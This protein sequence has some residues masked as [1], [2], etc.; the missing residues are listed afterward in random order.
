MKKESKI[1]LSLLSA[2]SLP[3]IMVLGLGAYTAMY[4]PMDEIPTTK[5]VRVIKGVH[6]GEIGEVIQV[7]LPDTYRDQSYPVCTVSIITLP[8]NIAVTTPC[9]FL[10]GI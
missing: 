6:V 1:T 4:D 2:I 10:K 9:K 8:D 5:Y 3:L 7:I